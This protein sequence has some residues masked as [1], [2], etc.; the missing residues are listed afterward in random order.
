MGEEVAVK[1][2]HT[3]A[4]ESWRRE[5]EIYRTH[6]LTHDNILRFKTAEQRTYREWLH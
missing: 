3:R 2:F 4:E 6:M 5:E 1:V